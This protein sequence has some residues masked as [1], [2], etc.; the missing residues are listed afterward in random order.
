MTTRGTIRA[1][2]GLLALLTV[3]ALVACGDEG[4]GVA[5]DGRQTGKSDV[6]TELFDGVVETDYGQLDLYWSP[7]YLGYDG[8]DDRYFA[9][10]VNG[11]V[12]AGD[13]GGVY[14]TLAR[15]S[16][17]SSVRIVLH[18]IEP[19]LTEEW[20]DVVEVSTVVPEDAQPGWGT[21]AQESGGQLAIPPGA[22]RIRVSARGRDAGRG[23]GEFA[24]NV[25][26]FYLLDLWPAPAAE[27]LIVRAGSKDARYWHR[28]RGGPRSD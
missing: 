2:Q 22:Y 18:D 25:V 28:Q 12:G 24:D 27:D 9:G 17:G 3:I 7:D 23:D 13:P 16:G 1:A 14:V 5:D 19:Q 20:E 6:S 8:T 11:L 4:N 10:Q 21:W 15:R 26:D